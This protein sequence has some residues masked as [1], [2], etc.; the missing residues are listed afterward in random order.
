[1]P[2][3][4]SKSLNVLKGKGIG[5]GKRVRGLSHSGDSLLDYN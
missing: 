3:S 4:Y 1:M 2:I 5:K